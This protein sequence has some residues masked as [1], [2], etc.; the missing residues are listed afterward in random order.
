MSM[1]S[2]IFSCMIM[3]RAEPARA[4]LQSRERAIVVRAFERVASGARERRVA[5]KVALLHEV[6][7]VQDIEHQH[8]HVEDENAEP[9]RAAVHPRELARA[10]RLREVCSERVR[11]TDF[12]GV[13]YPS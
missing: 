5:G 7:D 1:F 6:H 4:A 9:E 12:L 10:V 2:L 11:A 13:T 3:K 8:G